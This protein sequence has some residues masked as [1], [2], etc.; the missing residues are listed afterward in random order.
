ML[1]HLV[2]SLL[3]GILAYAIARFFTVESNAKLIGLVVGL[4]VFLGLFL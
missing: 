4:L 1:G 2:W 3:I